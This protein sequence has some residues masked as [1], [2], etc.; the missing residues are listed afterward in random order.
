MVKY[1]S[2]VYPPVRR[3]L[4][5][6]KFISKNLEQLS[7]DERRRLHYLTL[8]P[9]CMREDVLHTRYDKKEFMLF[10]AESNRIIGWAVIFPEKYT[11]ESGVRRSIH[12]RIYIY[13]QSAFRREGIGKKL[14]IQASEWGNKQEFDSKVFT[15]DRRSKE[16]FKTCDTL[17][18]KVIHG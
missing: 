16:F 9:S 6:I 10:L 5:P 12:H 2:I 8:R 7:S 15:H 13:V 14:V 17:P 18:V 4:T 11:L 1:S 3:S